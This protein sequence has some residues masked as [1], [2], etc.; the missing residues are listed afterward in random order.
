MKNLP[1]PIANED[2]ERQIPSFVAFT[3]HEVLCGTQAK[4][5]SL[6]NPKRTISNFRDIIGK[7]YHESLSCGKVT[8][9]A[10]D[11]NLPIFQINTNDDDLEYYSVH[12]ITSR[13]LQKLK[14]T[15]EFILST[16][17]DECVI[18]IPAHFE[19]NQKKELL[20]AAGT[21]GFTKVYPIHEP[22]AAAIAFEK[23]QEKLDQQILVLDLGA[24][25]FN[26]TLLS[27]HDGLYSVQDSKEFN[28]QSGNAFD[29][30]LVEFIVQEFRKKYKVDISDNR[31]SMQKLRIACERTKRS[32]SYQETAPCAVE[33]L[34]DGL[35]YNGTI[36]RGRFEHMA[37]KIFNACKDSVLETLQANNISANNIDKVLIVGGS[38][39]IPRFLQLMQT[40]FPSETEFCTNVEPDE[41]ISIGCALQGK[42]FAENDVQLDSVEPIVA[43]DHLISTLGVEAINGKCV[44]LIPKGTPLPV[45]RE[46]SFALADDQT[47]AYVAVYEGEGNLVKDNKLVAQVV[48]SEI[49]LAA[50]RVIEVVFTIEDHLVVSLSEKQS[51]QR[52][53]V[54]VK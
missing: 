37:D 34:Y 46:L 23:E 7:E 26:V 9:T 40:L 35:D 48:L 39:K 15:A 54:K 17:V 30:V 20:R 4:L 6:A 10:D 8:I 31:R 47:Q 33:S 45:R 21:A 22:V 52:V 50:E 49:P 1:E 38:S 28:E 36:I 29:T 19:D 12:D 5:Q 44:P 2:G 42:I 24:H 13:Y 27:Y 51:G 53:K 3:G 16:N 41:A 11:Q 14:E 43:V 32:L 18:S 25:Q